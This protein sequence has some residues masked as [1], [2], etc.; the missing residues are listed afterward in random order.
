MFENLSRSWVCIP[1]HAV[2]YSP[3]LLCAV[4]VEEGSGK[5]ILVSLL[6]MHLEK[7]R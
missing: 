6:M 7:P 4:K 1:L 2:L 3:V 5:H